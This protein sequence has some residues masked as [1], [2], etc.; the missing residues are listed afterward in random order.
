[1]GAIIRLFNQGSD[2][3]LYETNMFS[4]SFTRGLSKSVEWA[5]SLPLYAKLYDVLSDALRAEISYD[6]VYGIG[7]KVQEINIK[8]DGDSSIEIRGREEIDEL[9][10]ISADSTLY[11]DNKLFILQ[12]FELLDKAGWRFG[13]YRDFDLAK[14]VTYDLRTQ[15]Q[16]LAQ[17]SELLK[18]EPALQYRYGGVDYTGQHLLDVSLFEELDTTTFQMAP[19]RSFSDQVFIQNVQTQDK[20]TDRIYG[21]EAIGGNVTDSS[22]VKRTIRLSDALTDNPALML[23]PD[24]PI[25]E[26][27]TEL[28]YSVIPTKEGGVGGKVCSNPTGVLVSTPIIGETSGSSTLNRWASFI[29]HPIPG[30]LAECSFWTGTVTASLISNQTVNPFSWELREVDESNVLVLGTLLASGI[31]PASD[32]GANS[33]CRVVFNTVIPV[34]GTKRYL[35]RVGFPTMPAASAIATVRVQTASAAK[36]FRTD[37][38]ALAGSASNTSQN[39]QPKFEAITVANSVVKGMKTVE[40]QSRFT[41]QKTEGNATLLETN[42]AGAALYAWCVS[43]LQAK[44]L[45]LHTVTVDAM[46]TDFSLLPGDTVLIR[47]KTQFPNGARDEWE[48]RS[49]DTIQYDL[50][51]DIVT[52]TFRF[53]PNRPYTEAEDESVAVYDNNKE[54]AQ[55]PEGKI[56]APLYAWTLTE[57]TELVENKSANT[58]LADGTRAVFVSFAVPAAPAGFY[59]T[60]IIGS[61]YATHSN[62]LIPIRVE[63]VQKPTVANP[64]TLICKIAVRNAGWDLYDSAV[65]KAHIVWR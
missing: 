21:L 38:S 33:R 61:P 53:K 42:A 44:E 49:L 31:I 35:L 1:M 29:F 6:G 7:G 32:W 55:T 24:Y 17:L 4:A 48:T 28:S 36:T 9:Y 64:T 23:D 12:V 54:T 25:Y 20:F 65:V 10:D 39:S 14:L 40:I 46:G 34:E 27:T 59:D 58:T 52:T 45:D 50:K 43:T 13:L 37:F 18:Q 5:A 47:A 41:P 63:V 51:D 8:Y 2:D 19:N 11:I 56:V 60:R 30:D 3:C 16:L 57:L 62:V 22:G 15:K 26:E